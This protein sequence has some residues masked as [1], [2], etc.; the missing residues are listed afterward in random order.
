MIVVMVQQSFICWLAIIG[1]K[2]DCGDGS[3]K[4][5]SAGWLS[6][7][8]KVIVVM[9]QQKLHLLVGYHGH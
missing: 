2:S 4:A 3:T 6:W 1:T 8:L 5:S 7:S 9:V